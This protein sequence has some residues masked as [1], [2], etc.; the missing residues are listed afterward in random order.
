MSPQTCGSSPDH[1]AT[2]FIGTIKLSHT[3][4][5][6]CV[7][8]Q[9]PVVKD[10]CSCILHDVLL[11][12]NLYLLTGNINTVTFMPVWLIWTFTEAFFF[13]SGRNRLYI[14]GTELTVGKWN[15]FV[16]PLVSDPE[17]FPKTL[18]ISWV[19]S[20]SRNSSFFISVSRLPFSPALLYPLLQSCQT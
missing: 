2:D 17:V 15:S 14:L 11:Q 4:H 12:F 3:H 6:P 8:K 1:T 7:S 13:Y 9:T 19:V 5:S 20:G 16:I 10:V 18:W